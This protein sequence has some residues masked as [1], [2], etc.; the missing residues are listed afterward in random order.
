MNI[1]KLAT[2]CFLLS[3]ITAAA[4]VLA[5]NDRLANVTIETLPVT[6]NISMLI[7]SD[8]NIG[9][10]IGDDGLLIIDVQYPPL[11]TK[12]SDSP[13]AARLQSRFVSVLQCSERHI[14]CYLRYEVSRGKRRRSGG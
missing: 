7:G 11:W 12:Y 1:K 5:Q 6:D 13:F 2:A 14:D 3:G 9:V 4:A 8:G 10:S